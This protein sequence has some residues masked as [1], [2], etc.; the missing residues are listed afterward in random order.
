MAVVAATLMPDVIHRYLDD[1]QD[2]V[3]E[4]EIGS[5]SLLLERLRSGS[6]DLVVGRLPHLRDLAGLDW[7][8]LYID[9]HVFVVRAGHPLSNLERPNLTRVAS[10]AFVLPTRQTAICQE[11]DRFL[12]AHRVRLRGPQVEI[13]D[14]NFS[15]HYTLISD[16]VWFVSSRA[17]AADLKLGTLK[18]V[19]LAAPTFEAPIGLITRRASVEDP[20]LLRLIA[21]IRGA[22]GNPVVQG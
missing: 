14:V 18:R 8:Q 7:E 16:A 12:R 17:V 10:Y 3:V 5:Q 22:S 11:L 20:S 1:D 13:V 9:T 6:V 2:N 19:D 15:R 4:I 21:L